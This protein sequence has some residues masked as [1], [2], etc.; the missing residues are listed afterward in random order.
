MRLTRLLPSIIALALLAPGL[1]HAQTSKPISLQPSATLPLSGSELILLEQIVNGKW[2][3][4]QTTVN[5]FFTGTVTAPMLAPGAAAL[6][7]GSGGVSSPMLAPG[8][9]ALNLGSGGVS[10]S[11]LASG[12]AAANLGFTPATIINV[13]D[14]GAKCDGY[15]NDDAAIN[16]AILAAYNSP[17]YQNND[18]V[19]ITGPHGS[20]TTACVMNSSN[21][22]RFNKGSGADPRPRI[23]LSHMTWLCTGHGNVCLDGL[24]ADFIAVHD[25]SIRGD[26][27]APPEICIQ[28]GTLTGVS[29][30]WH[31]FERANCAGYFTFAALYNVGSEANTYIGETFT[32]A[33]TLSGPLWS[34]GAITGGSGYVDGVYP[35]VALTGG[36]CVIGAT[37]TSC[38]KATITVAGGA[39][40]SVDLN[41]S[42]DYAGRD[43]AVGDVLSASASSLGG[44]GSGF[45]VPVST[46]RGY[47]VVLDGANHWRSASAFTTSTLPVDVSTSSS[48]AT[49]VGV[50]MRGSTGGLWIEGF[51]RPTFVNS[52][53]LAAGPSCVDLYDSGVAKMG[54]DFGLNMEMCTSFGFFFTG[55]NANPAYTAF[56][57][58]GYSSGTVAAIGA[59]TNIASITLNNADILVDYISQPVPMFSPAPVFTVSGE[60][61]VNT[62]SMFNAP[63]SASQFRLTVGGLQ[64]PPGMGPVDILPNAAIAV[65]CSR[66]LNRGYS[67]PICKVQ[68]ASDN[69]TM[70]IYPDFGGN[71]DRGSFQAFCTNTT[72]GVLTAY[73]QS[74]NS[75][76]CTNS[77]TAN[78]PILTLSSSVMNYRS[79]MTWATNAALVCGASSTVNNLFASG[80]YA[81]ATAYQN[82][83]SQQNRLAYKWSGTAG[84]EWRAS[85]FGLS[86]YMSFIQYAT[87]AGEW[88]YLTAITPASHVY[89]IAYGAASL[90]NVPTVGIDGNAVSLSSTL[91]TGTVLTD[92]GAS[93]ILGNNATV[94]TRGFI[95]TISEF[96]AWKTTPT[97]TQREALRRN[98]GNYYGVA[99]Q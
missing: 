49:F 22:T 10:S 83:N 47:A 99:A 68:R 62:S 81:L 61:G 78:Q 21:F 8:A 91:P 84:W 5:A 33:Y 86:P 13:L 7:L 76:N 90:A 34:L 58:R 30:A 27:V 60:I 17:A 85:G 75:N 31:N 52:Y 64:T 82:S 50:N 53:V 12:A 11:M 71:L 72:C 46:I 9:A 73:D 38:S 63:S 25:F 23:E 67:G 40:T 19:E 48:L 18:A 15:T 69:A 55:P 93:L 79:T 42:G 29:S 94:G 35:G 95:G 96:V 66:L 14:Y 36:S 59:D 77:N 43:Y 92:S 2:A 87:T 51:I 4:R 3:T 37:V 65:S 24:G 6:N 16:A 97:P 32:N 57:W 45:S 20:V 89:D 1:C 28:V 88:D 70:D 44:S 41:T 39:V 74:G 98:E 26:N 56:R 54:Y 80:G